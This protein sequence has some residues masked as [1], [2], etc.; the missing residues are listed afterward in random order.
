MTSYIDL[1]AAHDKAAAKAFALKS[2][3]ARL[4]AVLR[5]FIHETTH[6]SPQRDDGSHHCRISKIMLEL[7]RDAVKSPSQETPSHE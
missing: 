7:A 2:E 6:L 1:L 5:L 3:V 4:K